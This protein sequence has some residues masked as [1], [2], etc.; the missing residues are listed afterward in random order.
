MTSLKR[1]DIRDN[2]TITCSGLAALTN[3]E[4]LLI[5]S[6]NSISSEALESLTLLRELTIPL[7]LCSD[8]LLKKLPNLVLL[9]IESAI[10]KYHEPPRLNLI[11]KLETLKLN[12]EF[13]T[14]PDFTSLQNITSLDIRDTNISSD[15]IQYCTSLTELS[16]NM[17]ARYETYQTFPQLRTLLSPIDLMDY[18]RDRPLTTLTHLFCACNRKLEIAHFQ[19]LPLL[20][21]VSLVYI[22]HLPI[23]KELG[24]ELDKRWIK[25]RCDVGYL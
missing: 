14:D 3:L 4:I 24:R 15:S 18:L 23:N 19:G 11:P 1:L 10:R 12:G 2:I 5:S 9:K 8:N 6:K 20:E 7:E 21:E 16:S 25:H 22:G 17:L 13:T